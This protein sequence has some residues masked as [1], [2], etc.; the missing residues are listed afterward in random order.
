MRRVEQELARKGVSETDIR[1]G[2][3]AVLEEEPVDMK[4]SLDAAATRKVA[5]MGN[6]GLEVQRRRLFAF[7]ARRG[8]E[9]GDIRR[10]IE[11]LLPETGK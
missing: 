11:Q 9:I 7:L 6:L 10:S 3:A 4:R 1:D 2:I 5:S 8:F